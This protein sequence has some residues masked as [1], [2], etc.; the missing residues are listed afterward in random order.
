M[1]DKEWKFKKTRKPNPVRDKTVCCQGSPNTGEMVKG[2]HPGC[3]LGGVGHST[4]TER[5]GL[6]ISNNTAVTSYRN[7]LLWVFSSCYVARSNP[8]SEQRQSPGCPLAAAELVKLLTSGKRKSVFSLSSICATGELPHWARKRFSRRTEL[9]AGPR[10]CL[11]R[12][13]HL[14]S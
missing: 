8:C 6:F 13:I 5:H 14:W 4:G 9:R 2:Q 7:D 11:C 12:N 1:L 3:G 10:H